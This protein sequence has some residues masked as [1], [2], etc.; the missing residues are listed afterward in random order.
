MQLCQRVQLRDGRWIRD[1]NLTVPYAPGAVTKS[2]YCNT[3]DNG[4][5]FDPY[6]WHQG[7]ADSSSC[8]F[9]EGFN[10]ALFCDL[11]QNA[12]I[13]FIG[14]SL[15][16]E[17]YGSLVAL[18][19]GKV[20]EALKWR[21]IYKAKEDLSIVQNVCGEKN[22]TLVYHFSAYLDDIDK[23]LNETFPTALVMNRGAWLQNGVHD[24]KGADQALH[25]VHKWQ[26]DCLEQ[27]LPCPFF[28]RTSPPGHVNCANFTE[29]ENNITIMEE[30]VAQNPAYQWETFRHENELFLQKLELSELAYEIIDGYEIGI[31]RP[32]DH[33]QQASDCLHNCNPG[34]P[35]AYNRILLHYLRLHRTP[36][37]ISRV[38]QYKYPWDRTSNIKPDGQDFNWSNS[39]PY[40]AE[41]PSG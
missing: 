37:D 22:T 12:V 16:F 33:K 15:T 14:D 25:H 18:M 4:S 41:N 40:A 28:Y 8:E 26:Q 36:A 5:G 3:R 7:A 19:G 35:D 10:T 29:P 9:Q 2:A 6:Q 21:C 30:Y 17:Q 39:K 13:L 20:S 27:N 11:M 23:V 32:D 38:S 34:V 31:R 1:V 24:L